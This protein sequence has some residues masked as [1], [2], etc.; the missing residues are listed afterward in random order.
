MLACGWHECA[1][2][3]PDQSIIIITTDDDHNNYY[4]GVLCQKIILDP[5]SQR[6]HC[7]L[8]GVPSL[9]SI[10]AII[11]NRPFLII[12]IIINIIIIIITT[13]GSAEFQPDDCVRQ[14]TFRNSDMFTSCLKDVHEILAPDRHPF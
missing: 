1:R 6:A 2:G 3:S 13:R 11:I 4:C 9:K 8:L 14:L 5:D 10:I 12:I 7:F